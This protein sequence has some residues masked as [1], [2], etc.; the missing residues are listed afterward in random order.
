MVSRRNYLII[1]MMM[2]V[3]F[4]LF[5]FSLVMKDRGNTYDTNI[6]ISDTVLT[7]GDAWQPM[8][9]ISGAEEPEG[10]YVVYIG[11]REEEIYPTIV[12]WCTYRKLNLFCADEV[13]D[14]TVNMRHEPQVILIDG[15][16]LDPREDVMPVLTLE[17]GRVPLIFCTIPDADTLKDNYDLMALF[18]IDYIMSENMDMQ[19]VHL[20]SKFLL[21]G[22][23]IYQS[24]LAEEQKRM[25]IPLSFP[26][27]HV[28]SGAKVYM[29]G[30]FDETPEETDLQPPLIWRYST[31]KNQI[32]VVNGD[33]I[34]NASGIG[35]LNAMFA[36]AKSYD[37]YPVVNA[38]L[39]SIA[40]F[41][42]L[43]DENE[44]SIYSRYSRT[45]SKMF[46]ELVWPSMLSVLEGSGFVPTCF[47]AP[48]YDYTDDSLPSESE[49][50]FFLRQL[51][52]QYAEA[53]ISMQ[54]PVE[55]SLAQKVEADSRFF[56]SVSNGYQYGAFYV[57]EESNQLFVQLLD[58]DDALFDHIHTVVF[59]QNGLQSTI[60]Y[61]TE[62]VS[63]LGT[64]NNTMGYKF[65]DDLKMRGYQTGL[66]Y[67]NLYLDMT[68]VAWP[69]SSEDEW[70]NV[71]EEFA[72][73][74]VTFWK[75]FENFDRVTASEAD[76]RVRNFLA[77][78]YSHMREDHVI[79][80]KLE[81]L[82]EDAWLVLRL[83][84]EQI[85][86]ITGAEY[87]KL[88]EDAYLLHAFDAQI[89]IVVE[90]PQTESFIK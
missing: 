47:M 76:R 77:L 3:L 37:V 20:F 5:Q 31:Q 87:K 58:S 90:Q 29:V 60:G 10:E 61:L 48:Q 38:Q 46:A 39:L 30:M 63:L 74:T 9:A 19:G 89:T 25:D 62:K 80:I 14:Y 18:G 75:P 83:H 32:F 56:A 73:N 65:S 33:Y 8:I 7:A 59:R 44:A 40:N 50:V 21:G 43:S 36:E 23:K 16:H 15:A 13:R 26:L 68:P 11:S 2:A 51:K 85:A 70:Q 69:Q 78:D 41:P 6:Y 72:S 52:E 1:A 4:G 71:S 42:G 79:Q 86:D 17:M 82:N 88:E 12:E 55:G 84:G 35:Y 22:E 49:L 45:P 57:D 67:S 81:H 24:V 54:N 53:G 64:T 27:Y 28:F 34:K 66:G